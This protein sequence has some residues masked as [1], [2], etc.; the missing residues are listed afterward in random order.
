[1]GDDWLLL[2]DMSVVE[3]VV[4]ILQ[5]VVAWKGQRGRERAS[6]RSV[7]VRVLK[8]RERERQA[9]HAGP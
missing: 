6:A 1:M 5:E 9:E 8:M 4:R 3:Y 2:F 7:R